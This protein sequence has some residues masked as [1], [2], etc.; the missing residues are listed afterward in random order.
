MHKL[1]LILTAFI[2][3]TTSF[4]SATGSQPPPTLAGAPS[5]SWA[6]TWGGS[7]DD[8][9]HTS[10]VDGA[11]NLY[12]AGE[13]S[14]T[15]DFDPGSGVRAFTSNG[16]ID[17]FLSKFDPNGTFL[18]ART[19]GGSGRDVPTSLG[20]DGLGHV[21]ITGPF[22][23]TVDFNPDPAL[24]ET[25]SSNAGSLNNIFL[26]Q[27]DANGTFLWTRTWGPADGGAESY[28]LAVDATNRV[29]V[30]GDFSGT[31]TNFN[32]WDAQHPDVHTNHLPFAGAAYDAFLSKFDASGTF[33]WAKTWGGEGYDDGTSVA[34]DSAGNLYVAGMYASKTLNFDPAGGSAGL[35]HP[36]HDSGA[37]VDV[38]LSKFD[39]N[40]NFQWVRTW[41]GQ[42]TEDAAETVFVDRAN[43]VYVAGRFASAS[44]DFNPAGPADLHSSNGNF[45]A[46]VSKFDP[47]G[48]FMWAKTWG[49][50]GWD[51]AGSLAVDTANNLYVTG[52]FSGTADFDAGSG[53]DSHTAVGDQDSFLSVYTPDGSFQWAKTW[54]GSGTDRGF[55]VTITGANAVYVVGGFQQTADLDPGSGLDNHTSSGARDVFFS[56]FLSLSLPPAAYLPLVIR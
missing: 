29:Y 8:Y 28:S 49:G 1:A 45:D 2:W 37:L 44:C 53:S 55:R 50:T 54:G 9:A 11:G 41:G 4:A 32:P 35:N 15:V 52:V 51:A 34:V 38:F 31:T 48:T 23:T 39:A 24:T 33:M 25:H 46:F 7:G 6:K 16:G 13:F 21:Y 17:V 14:G 26:S 42:G 30:Q 40:G 10:V 5:F 27:F 12:V 19:W 3:F 18:W 43:N 20:V 36:A 56:K 22:Q 47:N